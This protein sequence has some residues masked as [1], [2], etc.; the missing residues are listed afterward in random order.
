MHN[1]FLALNLKK[2]FW[3][4]VMDGN[5]LNAFTDLFQLQNQFYQMENNISFSLAIN[6]TDLKHSLGSAIFVCGMFVKVLF[7]NR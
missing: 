7:G 1:F 3:T 4:G 5:K 2:T 6:H